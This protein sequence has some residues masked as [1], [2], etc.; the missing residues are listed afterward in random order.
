MRRVALHHHVTE[1][2]KTTFVD[3]DANVAEV[4]L[5]EAAAEDSGFGALCFRLDETANGDAGAITG[6]FE[7]VAKE[8]T[9]NQKDQIADGYYDSACAF[10]VS[11]LRQL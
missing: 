10:L 9:D 3:D 1:L 2:I 5:E 7:R 6:L 11:V 4:L 8:L